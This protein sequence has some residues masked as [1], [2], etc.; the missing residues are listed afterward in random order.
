MLADRI[1]HINL[2]S[3]DIREDFEVLQIPHLGKK[4][5]RRQGR[6]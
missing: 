2:R 5:P 4:G 3:P 1:S 6:R